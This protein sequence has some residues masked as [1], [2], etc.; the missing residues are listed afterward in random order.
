MV[1]TFTDCS[2]SSASRRSS[3]SGTADQSKIEYCIR[4][5]RTVSRFSASGSCFSFP[6]TVGLFTMLKQSAYLVEISLYGS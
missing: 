1:I 6:W 5:L 4:D 3:D 2:E